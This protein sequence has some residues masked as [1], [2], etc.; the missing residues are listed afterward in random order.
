M[1]AARGDASDEIVGGGGGGNGSRCWQRWQLTRKGIDG[2]AQAEARTK[3]RGS[4][5]EKRVFASVYLL[6]TEKAG[7]KKKRKKK[8]E[9]KL[10]VFP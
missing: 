4:E 9:K 5:E 8:K 10:A 7:R 2:A 3:K 1:V 6:E